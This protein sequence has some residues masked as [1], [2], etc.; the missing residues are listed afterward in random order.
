MTCAE[1]E[2][3]L[4]DYIDGAL[5]A[6]ARGDFEHH[7]QTCAPCATLA[8]DARSA[9]E[10]MERAAAV[11]PPPAL[12]TRIL[13]TTNSGW[14]LKLRGRGFSGWINRTFAPVLR[15]RVVMGAL[16]TMMSITM[17]TRCGG[18]AP[19][20]FTAAELDPIRLWSSL[21]DRV[22]RIWDR[23]VKTYESMRL[24]YEVKSQL[25]QWAEQQREQDEAAAD[26]RA[27]QRKIEQTAPRQ[28]HPIT[29]QEKQP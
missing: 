25:D 15:P 17:L 12:L 29:K 26:A 23:G 3:L 10:F 11:E 5:P 4:A 19:H 24:V 20:T 9:V 27:D 18:P 1:F 7:L 22:Q 13:H 28:G 16:L 6:A 21:D 2:V 14:E 8:E